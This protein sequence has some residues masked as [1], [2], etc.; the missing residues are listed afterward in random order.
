M[1]TSKDKPR[2]RPLRALRRTASNSLSGVPALQDPAIH[3]YLSRSTN[4]F[5]LVVA[6]ILWSVAWPTLPIT[7]DLPAYALPVM[8]GAAVLPV[9]LAWASPTIGW[10]VSV[11]AAVVMALFVPTVD[12]W[13]WSIQVTHLIALLVLTLMTCLRGPL[14]QVP[15]VAASMMVL[16]WFVAPGDQRGGWIFAIGFIAVVSALLRYLF[17]SRRQLAEQTEET[18]LAQSQQA[19]LRERARIA[20]DL[21]DVVAHRMSMVV[22]M[23]QTAQYR[24]PDEL[25]PATVDE[26]DAIAS[27][28]RES[29]DEVR[30][31]LGVLRLDNGALAAPNPGMA[32]IDSLIAATRGAGVAVTFTDATDHEQI[33]ESAALVIY[34]IVQ[35]SLANA[36]RHAPGAQVMVALVGSSEATTL[37]V[38]NS[39]PTADPIDAGGSGVGLLGMGERAKSV[40]GQVTNG[41]TTDGGFA[42]HAVIPHRA[43]AARETA[44]TPDLRRDDPAGGSDRVD[45][46]KPIGTEQLSVSGSGTDDDASV[47]AEDPS[48]R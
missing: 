21:H 34:R 30:Q 11:V 37:S 3:A 20:R 12:G 17:A 33:G 40:G 47:A 28:A 32:D 46:S 24:L 16:L 6:L 38:V 7:H 14:R 26:F 25:T 10:G 19:V 2:R 42:V 44:D 4:V 15:L 1:G 5:F 35:E 31:L 8:S 43:P 18:E 13:P 48:H 39:F 36:T 23:A 45:L 41:P 27:A 9:A 22:V 29:L